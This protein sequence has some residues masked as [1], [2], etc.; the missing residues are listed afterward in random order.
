MVQGQELKEE[1]KEEAGVV[2]GLAPGETVYAL[3]AA[4]KY[5]IKPER[6]VLR[7]N[8]LNATGI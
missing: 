1:A 5:S 2:W 6:P 3:P 7:S 4:Q 8:A